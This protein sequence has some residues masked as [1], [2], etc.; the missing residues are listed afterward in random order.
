MRSA[1]RRDFLRRRGGRR[2]GRTPSA[3]GGLSRPNARGPRCP[4]RALDEDEGP[5]QKAVH[6][7]AV[8]A[9]RALPHHLV[10]H[11]RRESRPPRRRRRP[12]PH[13]G[14]KA[15]RR[16]CPGVG[17]DGAVSFALEPTSGCYGWR[18]G[19]W[20]RRG[21]RLTSRRDASAQRRV[22]RSEARD[23]RGVSARDDGE[24]PPRP[25]CAARRARA[26]S[27]R[28]DGEARRILALAADDGDERRRRGRRERSRTA[29][30]A[31]GGDQIPRRSPRLD[32]WRRPLRGDR[33]GGGGSRRG[34]SAPAA[35][36]ARAV[37]WALSSSLRTVV[38]ARAPSPSS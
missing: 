14:P 21:H 16:R 13:V 22:A 6:L 10:A 37:T 18:D 25:A 20:R 9:A 2:H 11:R 1:R 7:G 12:R 23:E 26:C 15:A 3:R 27:A 19:E 38:S 30:R 5:P 17:R 36:A 33:R 28:A 35:A 24:T 32:F 31:Q 4:R 34:D 29:R 8:R